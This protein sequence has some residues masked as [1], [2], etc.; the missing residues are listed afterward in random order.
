MSSIAVRRAARRRSTFLTG[1]IFAASVAACAPSGGPS[2]SPSDAASLPTGNPAPSIPAPTTA[3]SPAP[4]PPATLDPAS[5]E[6]LPT[7][8][9]ATRV[10]HEGAVS[11][12]PR[13]VGDR[14][15][16]PV[17][18]THPTDP[19]RVAVI[20]QHRGP[21]AAC[22]LNP[23]I[24]ISHDGGRSWRSTRAGPGARSGR[25]MG[26]HAAIAW[27]PGPSGGSRLYWANMTT[28]GCGDGRYSL[29]TA[30]S[31]NEGRTWSRLRVERRT[32][33][34]VG[35][36]PEIAVDRDPRSPNHGTVYVAYNWLGQGA[37][38]PGF[39]LL[40]SSD[41]GATWRAA[42][43][44]PAALAGGAKDWWRIAYRL[45]PAPD[46]SVYA[47]WYQVDL[48]R[49]DRRNIFSK[50]G[51]GNVQRLGIGVARIRFDAVTGTI[52]V[53]TSRI[54]TTVRE[55]AWTTRS[56]SAPGTSGNIR[57][58]PMW[59]YGFDVDPDGR[60]FLA[61]AGYGPARKGSARG[62]IRVGR[63]DDHGRTWS[64]VT[65]PPAPVRGGRQQSILRPNL[66]AGSGYILV[67]FRTLDDVSAGATMGIAY[68]LS[69][70]GGVHWT[71][72]ESVGNVRWR[73]S[74]LNGVVNGAG[75]R[76]RAERTA[77]GDV[78]W[79]YGDGRLAK[80]RAAGR[81]AIFAARI[82]VDIR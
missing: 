14:A 70:D 26:L 73:T 34:W 45:R 33:P 71:D 6:P 69:T 15:W 76:E 38:G 82:D 50:G 49:W 36:F 10:L 28:P 41:F 11:P 42:E 1:V 65:L 13:A 81:T 43:I 51:P 57:P 61:V 8:A 21:G 47:A 20:Y 54:A 23:I 16:E 25:G 39:R 27:G 3:M 66:V 55:T 32:R 12:T 30:Y 18:A 9:V 79:A 58:D 52:A 80:G 72:A 40:A 62:T 63:S 7:V 19:D 46:G 22:S 77:D 78:V 31:D 60:P 64:F 17:L 5:P 74:N 37:R 56:A 59:Q 4:S 44:K 67:T 29:T 2:R 48:R 53:G 75:L 68:S 24:R 35:G